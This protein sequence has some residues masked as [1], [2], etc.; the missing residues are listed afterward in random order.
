MATNVLLSKDPTIIASG[1]KNAIQ[2]DLKDDKKKRA[3]QGVDYYNYKHDI[4]DN[5][6]FILMIIII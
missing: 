4:L 5:R 1:I 2:A 3:Q 6:I